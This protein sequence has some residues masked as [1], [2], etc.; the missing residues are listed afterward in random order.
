MINVNNNFLSNQINVESFDGHCTNLTKQETISTSE[1]VQQSQE[2]N[3]SESISSTFEVISQ[4]KDIM[5]NQNISSNGE[6]NQYENGHEQVVQ[7]MLLD[8]PNLNLRSER[9]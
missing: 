6:L 9:K 1:V 7:S 4:Q 8:F 2:I 5:H 3:S